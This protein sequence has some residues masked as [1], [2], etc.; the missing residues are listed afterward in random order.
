MPCIGIKLAIKQVL[1]LKIIPC[2]MNRYPG[3]KTVLSI[4]PDKF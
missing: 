1:G 2:G 4:V 3:D